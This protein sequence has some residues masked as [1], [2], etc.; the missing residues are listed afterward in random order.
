MAS[1]AQ[2]HN[3]QLLFNLSVPAVPTN[4][5][6]KFRNQPEPIVVEKF[7]PTLTPLAMP[8]LGRP[9]ASV[10]VCVCR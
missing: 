4:M 5:A 6:A 9:A 3:N 8:M 2:Y 7:G 1:A 10:S